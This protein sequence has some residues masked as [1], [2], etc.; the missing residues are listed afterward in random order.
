MMHVDPVELIET[1][2]V[3]STVDGLDRVTIAWS[4]P[5]DQPGDR[6]GLRVDL[7]NDGESHEFQVRVV[8]LPRKHFQP[9]F[10]PCPSFAS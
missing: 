5:T 8:S 9:Y 4:I 1:R 2:R 10:V 6:S 3:V 7:L